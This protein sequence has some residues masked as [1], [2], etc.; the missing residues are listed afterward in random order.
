MPSCRHPDK[1]KEPEAKE[2]FQRK[3]AAY[4][5]L[6]LNPADSDDEPDIIFTG[7]GFGFSRRYDDDSDISDEDDFDMHDHFLGELF[8]EFL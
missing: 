8:W 2:M 1:N 5:R 7:F 4:D 3:H 6:V